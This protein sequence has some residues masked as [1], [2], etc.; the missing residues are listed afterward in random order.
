MGWIPA[1]ELKAGDFVKLQSDVFVPIEDYEVAVLD[2]PIKVYNFEVE[3]FHTYYVSGQKVLVHNSY[4]KEGRSGKQARLKE[5]ANDLKVGKTIRNE[6]QNRYRQKGRYSVPNGYELAH[7]K[8]LEAYK[9]YGY[10]HTNL[11]LKANHRNEHKFYK[12]WHKKRRKQ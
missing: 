10:K 5:I 11:Q 6:M 7:K 8:G 3:G 1:G 12:P 9:G 2:E 4:K